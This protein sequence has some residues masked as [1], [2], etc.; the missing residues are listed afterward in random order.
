V[1][2]RFIFIIWLSSILVFF[3]F[4]PIIAHDIQYTNKI[5]VKD[6]SFLWKIDGDRIH[7]K[8]VAKTTGWVGVGFN[9]SKIMKDANFILGYV[10]NGKPAITDHFG[11]GERMH[12]SDKKMGG[13]NNFSNIFGKEENGK[14]EIGFTIPLKSGDSNDQEISVD[15]DTIILLAYGA[16][17]DS[18][19][20][21]HKFRTRLT[22]NL[23]SGKY[24]KD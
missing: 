15:K 17:R 1:K 22:V 16:G 13:E 9:P 14:T 11:S 4:S 18:F 8:L 6:M 24:K 7:I 5:D 2:R 19:R 21:L 20:A 3:S 23:A 10:K 12:Q